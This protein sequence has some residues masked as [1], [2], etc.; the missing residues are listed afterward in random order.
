MTNLP[1]S[2]D[3]MTAIM[4]SHVGQNLRQTLITE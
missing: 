2:G 4:V 3:R 1:L